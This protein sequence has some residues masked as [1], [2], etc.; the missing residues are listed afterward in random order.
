MLSEKHFIGGVPFG[1][2]A[3]ANLSSRRLFAPPLTSPGMHSS[4]LV[5]VGGAVVRVIH[6]QTAGSGDVAVS[7]GV[8]AENVVE[9][10]CGV[11]PEMRVAVDGALFEVVRDEERHAV[12]EHGHVASPVV[13]VGVQ[14]N[15]PAV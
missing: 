7:G 10:H 1:M 6:A 11:L 3:R 4:T 15:S 8:N 12:C 9:L 13:L 2:S 14:R 5:G